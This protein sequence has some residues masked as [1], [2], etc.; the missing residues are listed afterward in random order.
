[1]V[2]A[3]HNLSRRAVLG[4]GVVACSSIAGGGLPD[5]SA[6]P[7]A[8]SGTDRQLAFDTLRRRWAR[9]LAAYRRAEARV[10]AFKAEEARLPAERRA[11][12]CDALELRFGRLDGLRLAALRRLLNLPAPDL[13]G[14]TLKLEF[15][16]A[17][18]A[19]ELDGCESCLAAAVADARRLADGGDCEIAAAWETDDGD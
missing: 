2:A 8:T 15:A 10:G 3:R 5:P 11:L 4:A 9:A 19:W 13:R 12:S 14:L 6:A 17:D 7:S 18:L 1:M 16:V